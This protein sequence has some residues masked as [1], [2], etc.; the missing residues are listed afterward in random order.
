MW[1]RVQSYS[2]DLRG[3]VL[4]AVDGG[5]AARPA[6]RLFQVSVSDI[7][8]APIRRRTTG[9][10]GANPNRGHRPRKLSARQERAL[11]AP[12]IQAEPDITLA[13]LQD[14]LQE[15]HGVRL[16]T[17]ALWTSVKRRG[18]TFKKNPGGERAGAPGRGRAKS[19][20]ESGP[21]VH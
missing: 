19:W 10:A 14:R 17:G 11:A 7:S 3:R 20:V 1:R 6:A 2:Q 21:A 4:A 12:R 9:E 16:S 8:K 15:A 5:M 13:R 18:F